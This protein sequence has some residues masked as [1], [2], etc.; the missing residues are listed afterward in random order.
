M[1]GNFGIDF[2]NMS[3]FHS[4]GR[5]FGL[6]YWVLAIVSNKK[7]NGAEIMG[8]MNELSVG[9]WKPSAGSLY[10]LLADLVKDGYLDV[11]EKDNKKYY[12]ITKEGSEYLDNSWFPWK[13][14]IREK[15]SPGR[16]YDLEDTIED[17]QYLS[18]FLIDN[19]EK[20]SKENV[21]SIKETIDKLKS[22]LN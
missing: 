21:N 18:Q 16:G 3:K 22:L 1:Y 11:E 9:F 6:R 4:M 13:D 14:I 5:G 20:L 19:K 15:L 7:M 17:I 8:K 12:S 2:G 10:P